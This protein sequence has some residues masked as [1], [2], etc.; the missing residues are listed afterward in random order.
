MKRH[1]KNVTKKMLDW[2]RPET[3]DEIAAEEDNIT[4]NRDR[5]HQSLR[6]LIKSAKEMRHTANAFVTVADQLLERTLEEVQPGKTKTPPTKRKGK[7]K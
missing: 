1:V 2:M 5:L 4:F 3:P 7:P 6:I